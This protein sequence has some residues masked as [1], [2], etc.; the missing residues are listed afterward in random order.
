MIGVSS[1]LRSRPLMQSKQSY[2][3]IPDDVSSGAG[4]PMHRILRPE[5]N[6]ERHLT[7]IDLIA[8]GVGGTVG[9]GLFVL[10]GL[11]AHQYAGPA[12]VFSWLVSGCTA[13][14]SGCCYAELSSRIPLAGG[15]YAYNYVSVGELGA[16]VAAACLSLEYIAASAAGM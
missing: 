4:S 11:V 3:S 5:Q 15:A 1:S 6:L 16:V 10:A 14:L 9:S 2:S 12:T 13:C 8:V 7:L